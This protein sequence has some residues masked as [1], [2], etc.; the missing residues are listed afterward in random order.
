MSNP[1]GVLDSIDACL[2]DYTL[3]ADAM[4]W[5][6]D[7]PDPMEGVP[8]S[9]GDLI[10]GGTFF[11]CVV[12]PVHPHDGVR[13]FFAPSLEEAWRPL[14]GA[15]ITDITFARDETYERADNLRWMPSPVTVTLTTDT[16]E[17]RRGFLNAL[18][19]AFTLRWGRQDRMHALKSEYHRRHRRRHRR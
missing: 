19:A 9:S 5:A 7:E 14:D 10:D 12:Q 2:R 11:E 4:R 16:S 8:P 17:F 13:V 18:S 15:V 1:D 6:P 3:S